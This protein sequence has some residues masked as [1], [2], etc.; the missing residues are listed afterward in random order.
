MRAQWLKNL[1]AVT[2]R[3]SEMRQLLKK[4]LNE[5]GAKS[6]TGD[7][8]HITRQIGM[9]SFTG[10]TKEQSE[11]MVKDYSVYMTSNGRISIAGI[12]KDNAKYVAESIKQVIEK[13]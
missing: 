13:Y 5:V 10:L 2:D 11:A 12:T 3:I 6:P 1:K 8:D 4:N 9:F 7:W